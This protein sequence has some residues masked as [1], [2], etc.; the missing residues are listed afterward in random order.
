MR[1]PFSVIAYVDDHMLTVMTETAKEVCESS[2]VACRQAVHRYFHQRRHQKLHS[3]RIFLGNDA[4]GD[5]LHPTGFL[6]TSI[7]PHR[8]GS[9]SIRVPERSILNRFCQ[10]ISANRI[11]HLVFIMII[12]LLELR[13]FGNSI[14]FH[15]S[16]DR[17]AA[18]YRH[19]RASKSALGLQLASL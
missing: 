9:T 12:A 19:L 6:I 4:R 14:S 17:L 16:R 7:T 3:C 1:M 2:R 5:D 10:R 8:R 13:F 15:F 11:L 18:A